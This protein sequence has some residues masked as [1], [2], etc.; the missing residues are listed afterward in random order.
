VRI[1]ES[2]KKKGSKRYKMLLARIQKEYEHLANE[3]IDIVNKIGSYLVSNFSLVS[4]QD[5][6]VHSWSK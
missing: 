4:F 6:S 3:K 1:A 5:D 2:R